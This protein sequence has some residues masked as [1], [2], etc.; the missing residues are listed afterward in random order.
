[1]TS[2]DIFLARPSCVVVAWLQGGKQLESSTYL[3][4]E[5]S[6]STVFIGCCLPVSDIG[7]LGLI[8]AGWWFPRVLC[9]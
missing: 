5:G 2:S 9:V 3:A 7:S 8:R 1:M 4:V 6:Q